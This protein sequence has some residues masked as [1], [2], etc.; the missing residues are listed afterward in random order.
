MLQGFEQTRK[1]ITTLVPGVKVSSKEM[2]QA[3]FLLIRWPVSMA[4]FAVF[5]IVF[6][7]PGFAAK[8]RIKGRPVGGEMTNNLSLPSIQT[9]S[10]NTIDAY[11]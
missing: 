9:A 4:V 8:G 2:K 6:S 11:W 3:A 7:T 10:A 1:P 5:L